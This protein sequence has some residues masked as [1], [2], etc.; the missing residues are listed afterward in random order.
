MVIARFISVSNQKIILLS[1]N[2]TLFNAYTSN[3]SPS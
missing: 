2:L 3:F 1:K